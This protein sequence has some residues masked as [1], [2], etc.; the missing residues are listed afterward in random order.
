MNDAIYTDSVPIF[1]HGRPK[2][3]YETNVHDEPKI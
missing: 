2:K 3:K 1:S